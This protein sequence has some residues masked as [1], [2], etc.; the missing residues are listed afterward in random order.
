MYKFI[1]IL[2]SQISRNTDYEMA[3][4]TTHRQCS[5]HRPFYLTDLCSESLE[6]TLMHGYYPLSRLQ[7]LLLPSHPAPL[8]ILILNPLS[9]N[10]PEIQF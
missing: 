3:H 6:T 10:F 4:F 2:K 7:M 9:G 5:R 1:I 8:T